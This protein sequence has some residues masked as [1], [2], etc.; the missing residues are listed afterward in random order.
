VEA[1]KNLAPPTTKRKLCQFI[2]IVNYYWDM[3]IRQSNILAPLSKLTTK[4][5]KWQWTEVNQKAF[6]TIKHIIT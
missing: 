5:A 4:T 6:E 2:G 3:W 1:I